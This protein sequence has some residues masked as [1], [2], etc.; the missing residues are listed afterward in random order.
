MRIGFLF[1]LLLISAFYTYVAFVELSFLTVSGRL[2]PGFFPRLIGVG[3]ILLCLVSLPQD[4][5]RM[6]LDDV[7]TGY[8]SVIAMMALLSGGL[9]MLFSIVGGTLAMAIFL[10][11]TLSILNRGHHLQNL[12]IAVL[13]PAAI[14]YLFDVWLNASMP[15]GMISLP[16]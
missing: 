11:V 14:Y 10:L 9:V 7:M 13:L 16:I 3:L 5:R 8:W 2:G 15:E 6:R 12:A 1:A 4:L